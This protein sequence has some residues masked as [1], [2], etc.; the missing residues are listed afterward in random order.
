M[1]GGGRL[2]ILS[3]SLEVAAGDP[4]VPPGLSPGRYV[5]LTVADTGQGMSREVQRKMFE[6]FFTTKPPGE[7]TGLGLAMVYGIVKNHGGQIAVAS[8]PGHGT[9]VRLYLPALEGTIQ[10]LPRRPPQVPGGAETVLVVDDE[11]TILELAREILAD[12]G[13]GVVLARNGEEALHVYGQYGDSIALV[14]LDIVMPRL[15]GKETYRR[16]KEMDPNVKVVVSSGF[17]RH[18]QAHD[19]MEMG[20]DA[21]VQK[22]YRPEDLAAVVRQTLDAPPKAMEQSA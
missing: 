17:S 6:P 10:V 12:K 1:P 18:G 14:V 8:R 20:A 11:V 9:A 2:R 4:G 5:R 16:L 21:F 15:G 22:P 7:G 19:L 3:E 13:Y